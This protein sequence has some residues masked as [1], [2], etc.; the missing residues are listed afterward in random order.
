MNP[1]P[2]LPSYL[3][4]PT[5]NPTP[6]LP[7]HPTTFLP[8]PP[9]LH[10]PY[11]TLPTHPSLPY[12][13]PL[14]LLFSLHMNDIITFDFD[15][16]LLMNMLARK[17][18]TTLGNGDPT[19]TK[20]LRTVPHLYAGRMTACKLS[21]HTLQFLCS[22]VWTSVFGLSERN[23]NIT[24]VHCVCGIELSLNLIVLI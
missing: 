13:T 10:Q 14:H 12:H 7:S 17:Y 9:I 8:S 4:I 6:T 20:F 21:A 22:P 16:A 2:Y 23:I 24:D 3:P 18:G 5:P 19:T 11:P 1:I 15:M